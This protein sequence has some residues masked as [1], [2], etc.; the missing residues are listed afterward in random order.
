M[1]RVLRVGGR[2]PAAKMH[3]ETVVAGTKPGHDEAGNSFMQV[4]LLFLEFRD[5]LRSARL[6]DGKRD[7][8]AGMQR[9]QHTGL[10]LV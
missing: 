6:A 8:V 2:K 10:H 1:S 3:A 7:L 4:P 5:G 9:G